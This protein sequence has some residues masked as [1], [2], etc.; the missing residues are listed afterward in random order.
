MITLR[1]KAPP[2][3]KNILASL[4]WS[5]WFG[6]IDHVTKQL[7]GAGPDASVFLLFILYFLV[8][9]PEGLPKCFF[10]LKSQTAIDK[11]AKV[12]K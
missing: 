1:C 7:G 8:N 6:S 9:D 12:Q 5:P 2:G 3:S 11:L 10:H 4:K